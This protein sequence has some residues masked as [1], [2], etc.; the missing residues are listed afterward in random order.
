MLPGL[1]VRLPPKLATD[2]LTL[3]VPEL[4]N[5]LV[6]MFEKVPLASMKPLLVSVPPGT[7]KVPF[8]TVSV[9]PAAMVPT[10]AEAVEEVIDR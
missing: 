5:V 7:V 9:P 10:L 2:A 6:R 3:T 8:A 4:E 1:L